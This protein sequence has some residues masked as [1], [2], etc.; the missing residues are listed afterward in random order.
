MGAVLMSERSGGGAPCSCCRIGVSTSTNPFA[1]GVSRTARAALLR[2]AVIQHGVDL[3][4]RGGPDSGFEDQW[5][6][7][8][9]RQR[10]QAPIRR[11][12]DVWR[13]VPVLLAPMCRS[14]P[15]GPPRWVLR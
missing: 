11:G 10:S 15:P 5:L 12:A 9:I 4:G 14:S 1:N 6:R 7:Y 8:A 13:Q 2:V 3:P